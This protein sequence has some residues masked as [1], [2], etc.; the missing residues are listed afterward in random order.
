VITKVITG[1][2][3]DLLNGLRELLPV[4]RNARNVVLSDLEPF[5]NRCSYGFQFRTQNSRVGVDQIIERLVRTAGKIGARANSVVLFRQ[6]DPTP[7]NQRL[8]FHT[9]P[10]VPIIKSFAIN[11]FGASSALTRISL[12]TMG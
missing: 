10:G 8:Q 9:R 2:N 11:W 5:L 4:I 6:V 7:I 1:R 12:V 3:A